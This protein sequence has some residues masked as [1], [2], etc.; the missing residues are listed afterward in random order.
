MAKGDIHKRIGGYYDD[1]DGNLIPCYNK[2]GYKGLYMKVGKNVYKKEEYCVSILVNCESIE[3]IKE[4]LKHGADIMATDDIF[5]T[6]ILQ[7]SL[8]RS[9]FYSNEILNIAIKHLKNKK[10]IKEFINGNNF[11]L[12]EYLS[13]STDTSKYT[14][15]Q[16]K[17]I[18]KLV[19]H[20]LEKKHTVEYA[21]YDVP[22]ENFKW[23]VENVYTTS[24][25][26]QKIDGEYIIED[27]DFSEA[28]SGTCPYTITRTWTAYD[29][30]D[31]ETTVTQ[32][33]TIT[34]DV[35][36]V[37]SNLPSDL[38]VE[39]GSIPDT[40]N[41]IATITSIAGINRLILRI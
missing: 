5:Q 21:A 17:F 41:V 11:E 8:A 24:D 29:E 25:L 10:K 36:P 33:I 13:L 40:A 6:N 16:K 4:E 27:V 35:L 20:G 34:D 30:C 22:Y 37:L 23:L 15:D 9:P 19:K 7:G 28:I 39:C 18:L 26:F 12:G 14:I 3:C 1:G 32:I 2:T 38:T 31:N